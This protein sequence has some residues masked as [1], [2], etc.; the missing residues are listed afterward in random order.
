MEYPENEKLREFKSRFEIFF[1]FGAIERKLRCIEDNLG[2]PEKLGELKADFG[3]VA[4]CG[5]KTYRLINR[6]GHE[7]FPELTEKALEQ[8]K[9]YRELYSRYK[10]TGL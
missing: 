9:K 2:V 4:E 3:L 10:Q 8:N 6:L 7:K 5:K 1:Y